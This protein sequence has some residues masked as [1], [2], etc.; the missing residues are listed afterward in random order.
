MESLADRGWKP[1]VSIADGEE[2]TEEE[3]EEEKKKKEKKKEK[4]GKTEAKVSVCVS[5]QAGAS[6]RT[7]P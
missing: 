7:G 5:W 1:I 4:Q 6:N 2:E 3:E